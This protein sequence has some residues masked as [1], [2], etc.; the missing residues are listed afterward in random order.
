MA[1]QQTIKMERFI[2]SLE[3]HLIQSKVDKIRE[4]IGYYLNSNKLYLRLHQTFLDSSHLQCLLCSNHQWHW[5]L[6]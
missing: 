5:L 4:K 6:Q 3:A 2:Q 1:L